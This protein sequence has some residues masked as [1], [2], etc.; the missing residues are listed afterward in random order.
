MANGSTNKNVGLINA[1]QTCLSVTLLQKSNAACLLQA[2]TIQ[3]P[4]D[5]GGGT[6]WEE[7]IQGLLNEAA[8]AAGLKALGCENAGGSCG[9]V[10]LNPEAG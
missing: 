1:S 5:L 10:G 6:G 9:C 4:A 7:D 3:C 8:V 2:G